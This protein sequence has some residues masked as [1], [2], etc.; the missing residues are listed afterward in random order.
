MIREFITR[1]GELSLK[2]II[3]IAI[4]VTAT[5]IATVYGKDI[6]NYFTGL[7]SI[8]SSTSIPLWLI[9]I[10]IVLI[11]I[12]L[13]LGLYLN[14]NRKLNDDNQYVVGVKRRKGNEIEIPLKSMGVNW[15]ACIP[16][17]NYKKEEYI[18]LDGPFCPDCLME[19][20]WNKSGNIFKH[21]YW[22]CP[23]CNKSYD[24]P[25]FSKNKTLKNI[26]NICY[27]DI[28]RKEKFK[29]NDEKR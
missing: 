27:A 4:I 10:I 23:G 5:I 15:I 12:L 19:L 14:R 21:Y 9:L 7:F 16:R 17:Q 29:K 28:F 22:R 18:W 2:A 26:E 8:I 1:L 6:Y 3:Q 25:T 24:R 20:E 11:L 13:Y